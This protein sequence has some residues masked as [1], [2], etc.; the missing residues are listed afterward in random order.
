MDSFESE[1]YGLMFA[2]DSKLKA[3]FDEAINK[4]LDNG[5]YTEIYNKWFGSDPDI[6]NLKAQQ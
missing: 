3:E 5:K 1:Y 2:K 6:E 4:V